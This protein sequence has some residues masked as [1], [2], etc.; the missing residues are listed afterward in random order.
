MISPGSMENL[1]R[2]KYAIILP[3]GAADDPLPQLDGRTPLEVARIPNMNW[4]AQHGR[5]GL[6]QTIPA[7]FLSGTDVGT[8]SVFGYDPRTDHPGRAPI[9]AAAQGL[10]AGPDELI[11]RCNFVTV[12]DGV[13]RS[14]NAGHIT[15]P[16]AD[17]LIADLNRLARDGD[18]ALRGCVFHAGVNYRN[19]VIAS[20]TF[21]GTLA[22]TPPHD[23]PNQPV[24]THMPRGDGAE[25]ACAIMARAEE[26]CTGHEINRERQAA[27]R[28][29]VTGIWLWGQGRPKALEPFATR[30]GVRGVVI[31]AVD[32]IRGLAVMMGMDLIAVPG[33]TGYLDTNYAGKGEH[34]VRALDEYDLVVVH[35]EA[36]D[37]A[38]HLG[39]AAEKIKALERTDEHVV[40]PLLAALQRHKQ[41]RILIAPDHVTSTATTQH[42]AAPPPFCCGGS[43]IDAVEQRPFH[44]RAAAAGGLRVEPGYELM[45]LFF[46]R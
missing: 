32:I 24:A 40:G 34:A 19:L 29:P 39:N 18:A 35:V 33:A 37:E 38:A 23:I 2:M 46:H 14:F 22:C 41:W 44:E 7:G 13:M 1:G 20:N 10:K 27:G 12:L 26:L 11:F 15:Q 17:R 36:P 31:S 43:D 3:D 21:G 30:F 5:L 8:L 45:E 4:I 42:G 28:E 6:V 16:E 25:R 9:E